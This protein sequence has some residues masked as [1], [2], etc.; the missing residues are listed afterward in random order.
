MTY[1]IDAAAVDVVLAARRVRAS[2]SALKRRGWV[3]QD[4]RQ[5][6][7]GA[8]WAHA[9]GWRLEHCGH[10]TALTPWLLIAPNGDRVLTG[11]LRAEAP[12]IANGTA[13]PCM[14]MATLYVELLL[15]ARAAAA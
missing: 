11:V 2:P 4:D 8:C 7:C 10:P 6:T 1:A 3:R 9:A 5:G 15:E 13:W 14:E 12:N